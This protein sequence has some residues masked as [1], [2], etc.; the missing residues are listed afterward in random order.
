MLL[1]EKIFNII[2]KSGLKYCI[3][4]K[5]EMM[6]EEIPSDIDMM[7]MDADE[8]FLDK[9]VDEIASKTGLI[10]T[11]KICQG[12][13]EF[14]YI[15]SYPCPKERFQLQLDFYR[16][17]SRRGYLNIMPAE[18][19]IETRRFYKCFYV[20]DYYIELKYMW[21]RR[22]IK[23]DL[24]EEHI[25]IAKGLY[26]RS[27]EEYRKKLI[28]D[29]GEELTDV[30]CLIMEKEDIN[31]FYDNFQMFNK[32][33]KNISRKNSPLII[34]LKYL[35]FLIFCVIPKRVFHKCGI[36]IAFLAPDGA[37]KSTI[38]EKIQN[39]V[40]GSFYGI[41]NYYF[42]PHIFKNLGAYKP[43]NPTIE[44]KTNPDPHGKKANG[45][46]KSFVR[47]MFYNIDFFFG[48]LIKIIP[49]KISKNLIIFD[50]YYYDYYVDMKRFQYNMPSRIPHFFSWLISKPNI[51]F[52]LDAPAEVIYNRKKEL[53]ISEIER[54]R[55][56]Y[57]KI[58]IKNN[59]RI[60][61]VNRDIQTI[62]D[63]VTMQILGY[64]DEYTHKIMK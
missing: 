63:D 13:Y 20:P 30:I 45:F 47:F 5:Y 31:I 38:I 9:L 25:Q 10:V 27:P 44:E 57:R 2:N 54:A 60:I 3:Q 61:D 24:N 49:E 33:A 41:K 64:M 42:R 40:S 29:F 17:I 26:E 48:N 11:Q 34:R 19:M 59:F 21:I 8:E 62:T 35:Y 1:L 18:E 15:I 55:E 6:P 43:I 46:I 4:N 50:R 58:A 22:T 53:D 37:G 36:S 12:Y 52:V 7:Y 39:P 32:C 56:E 23:K 14:T 51:V 28:I 16:A